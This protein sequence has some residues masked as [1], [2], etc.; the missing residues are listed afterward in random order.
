MAKAEM[1]VSFGVNTD[2]LV[3]ADYDG[4]GQTDVAAWRPSNGT[5]Y[6]QKSSDGSL[7]V[8]GWGMSGDVPVPGIQ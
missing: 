5:W 6:I 1:V 7:N 4:D 2:V 8:V 3:A